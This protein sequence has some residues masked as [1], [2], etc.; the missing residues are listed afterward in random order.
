MKILENSEESDDGDE[1]VEAVN[2]STNEI[3][4]ISKGSFKI[5]YKPDQKQK[6]P[7]TKEQRKIE[8][9]PKC[10]AHEKIEIPKNESI[11]VKTSQ[12]VK[13]IIENLDK[14]N[15]V[16]M[17]N[18][19]PNSPVLVEKNIKVICSVEQGVMIIY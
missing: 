10:Q 5:V 19:V 9:L 2:S 13:R 7:Q 4:L 17:N 14:S 11:T 16:S 6:V 8:N 3:G 12:G 15:K 1:F 18:D